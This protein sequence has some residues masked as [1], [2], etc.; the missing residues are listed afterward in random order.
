MP[1]NLNILRPEELP[2]PLLPA[3]G[4]EAACAELVRRF[5]RT[6]DETVRVLGRRYIGTY[7]AA[8]LREFEI[9][10]E[11]LGEA[12]AKVVTWELGFT[13]RRKLAMHDLHELARQKQI[14]PLL[15]KGAANSLCFYPQ[16][17][18]RMSK[19]IDLVLPATEVERFRPGASVRPD[20]VEWPPDHVGTFALHTIP[21]EIH[22]RFG[23]LPDWGLPADLAAEAV[24]CPGYPGFD[25]PSPVVAFTIALLHSYKHIGEM[26]WDFIDLR[27]ILKS[28]QLNWPAVVK[29]WQET[30]L[31]RHLFPSLLLTA[32]LTG[33]VP[34]EIVT[35]LEEKLDSADRQAARLFGNVVAARRF[36]LLKETRWRCWLEHKSFLRESLLKFAGSRAI[37]AKLT[38]LA[39]DQPGFWWNH[40]FVLPLKR[41]WHILG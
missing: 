11:G 16:E 7:T 19:D 39:P 23:D 8:A 36:R 12:L 9:A 21:V 3:A 20:N 28:G 15:I 37:T 27:Q 29:L 35:T 25:V 18:Q 2:T 6:P 32:R 10:D 34:R 13:A 26:T 22:F 1:L 14:R 38:G 24:P 5:R 4:T 31:T 41:M 40:L 33:Q 17:S 30:G